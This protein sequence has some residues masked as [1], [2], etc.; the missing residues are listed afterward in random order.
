MIIDNFLPQS[1]AD[2]IEN[3]VSSTIF[4]WY[5][6]SQTIGIDNTFITD[7]HFT[8]DAVLDY[9]VNSEYAELL[10]PIVWLFERE[11]CRSSRPKL[12]LMM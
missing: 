8:H 2:E 4:P 12:F 11:W 9:A 5:F 1:Y 7:Y 10:K 3:V 6:N